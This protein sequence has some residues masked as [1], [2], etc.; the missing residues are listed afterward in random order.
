VTAPLN[1]ARAVAALARLQRLDLLTQPVVDFVPRVTPAFVKPAHLGPLAALIERA[2]RE[3]VRAVVSVPPRHGK[4]ETILHAVVR[5]LARYPHRTVGYATYS[6]ML[7]HSKSREARNYARRAGV[8]IADDSRALG[9]WRTPLGGG[10]LAAGV[11]G[12]WTGYGVDLLVVDDPHRNRD[13]AESRTMRDKAYDW[14]TSTALTRVEPGGSVIIN[15]AR[16]HASDMIGRLMSEQPGVWEVLNLPALDDEGVALW[17]E[18]WGAEDLA[19]KRAEIGE[20]DFASLYLGSPR[21][22]G[23]NVFREPARYQAPDI[24]GRRILIGVDVAAT[25]S[26]RSDYSVAVVMA[27]KGAGAKLEADILEVFRAQLEIPALC[28][29]LERL[30][31]KWNAPLIVESVGVGKAVPQLLKQIGQ[32]LRVHEI[33]PKADKFLRAQSL[34]AAWNEG[35]VRLPT[36]GNWVRD[37]LAEMLAF[38]GVRDDHDDAVDATAHAFNHALSTAPLRSVPLERGPFARPA[39]HG[40]RDDFGRALGGTVNT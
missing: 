13:D 24:T 15:A 25:V 37:Y 11:G 26:T 40:P 34:A 2:E 8:T 23:T 31:R 29:E 32:R 12:S 4:T 21:L 35:R 9:E 19:D 6:M 22:R 20:Y 33:T 27:V 7:A 17:P 3:P 14:L 38:T 36:D 30:Q 16:W 1:H 10:L 39:I 28:V 5:Y 18:R